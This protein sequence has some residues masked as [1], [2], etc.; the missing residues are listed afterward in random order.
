MV[1]N[2]VLRNTNLSLKAKGLYAYMWSL[3]EDWDYSVSGLTKVLKEG[4]DAINEALK[5]LEREGYLVRTILRSGGKFSDMDYMLN[6]TPSPFTGFPHTVNPLTENPQQSN[7]IQTKEKKTK[8]PFPTEKGRAS[9]KSSSYD[10]V[11]NAPENEH[12]KEALIKWVKAC[13]NRG[14]GF[15]YKTLE[16]WASILRDNA[17]ESLEAA[18]AIVDQS[19][20]A[21]WKDLYKLK[22]KPESKPR[23]SMERFDPDKDKLATGT[24]GKPLVY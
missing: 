19:I 18:L 9:K 22:K 6:E 23:A 7:T 11:F 5:E 14:V 10:E 13:K 12:I 8:D 24:D 1:S 16:R 15:Q 3:P 4:R 17:G 20:D 21:G 2:H